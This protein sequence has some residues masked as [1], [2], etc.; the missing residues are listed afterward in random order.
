MTQKDYKKIA[1]VLREERPER[2][3][4]HKDFAILQWSNGARDEWETIII[5][6]ARMLAADNPRF[7]KKKFL[8]A[9]HK[10]EE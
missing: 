2:Q 8:A 3:Q 6:M 9:C 10:E 7:D 4:D 5:R 1:E